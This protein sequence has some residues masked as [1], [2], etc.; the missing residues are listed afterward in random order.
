MS[1]DWN[2]PED[3]QAY[4]KAYHENNIEKAKAYQKAYRRDTE[5]V[6]AYFKTYCEKNHERLKAYRENNREKINTRN[7]VCRE[8]DPE[9]A[10]AYQKV[11]RE[12]N[13]AKAK[14]NSKDYYENNREKVISNSKSYYMNNREKIKARKKDCREKN[15]EKAKAYFENNPN[16]R[17]TRRLRTRIWIALKGKTKSAITEKLLGCS[18]DY[19]RKY[20]FSLFIDDMIITTFMNGKIHIHHIKDCILFDL[21][22]EEEQKECF[23]YK[24]LQPLW[25]KDNLSKSKYRSIK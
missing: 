24:N 21:T 23:N 25:A 2:N 22:K 13:L 7:K 5:K 19:F 20:F 3:V 17:I 15:S 16:A 1:T 10:K 11:Y 12:N 14:E 18:F 8:R 6:K 9:K 4:Q